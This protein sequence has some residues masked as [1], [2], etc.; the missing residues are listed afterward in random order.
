[1]GEE[2]LRHIVKTV[3]K[4]EDIAEADAKL[5]YD[6]FNNLL[7]DIDNCFMVSGA[8]RGL[9]KRTKGVLFFRLASTPSLIDSARIAT[10]NSKSA[11]SS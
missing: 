2:L 10:I 6:T 7:T 9:E 3:V 8:S 1:M 5:M 4:L 11:C